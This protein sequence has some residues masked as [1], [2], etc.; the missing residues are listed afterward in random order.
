MAAMASTPRKLLGQYY[1]PEPVVSSLMA[2]LLRGP[3]DRFLDPACGDG[4]FLQLHRR[5]TGIEYSAEACRASRERA[6]LATV[7]AGDFFV[8]AGATDERFDAV[9]GNPPFIRYQHF[10]G[11][12]RE[13][14]LSLA[15]RIGA[16]FSGL[17]SSWAPFVA[18]AAS[19]LKP[20][21]RLGFVVPAELGHATY[22][23]PLL[24]ALCGHFGRLLVVAVR[25]KL[26]PELSEDAW[27]LYGEGF[28][29]ST[30]EIEL[31][32]RDDFAPM[33]SVPKP[34]R[35]V[36]LSDWR[37]HGRRLRKHLLPESALRL[38]ADLGALP[39]VRRVSD[40]AGVGVGYVTGANDFFHLTR[41][42]VL[43]W[44]IP[45]ELTRVAVRKGDQLPAD[46]VDTDTVTGWLGQ[47]LP[48]LLL[49]LPPAASIPQAVRAY[50]DSP[51]G[52]KAR[53]AYK[54]RVREPWYSVPG[55]TVPDGFL[56]CMCGIEGLLVR[57][58]AGCVCTNSVHA[59][60][61]R[62]GASFRQLQR[63][64]RTPLSRLSQEVEGHPL[65][66]GLLKLEPREA[67]RVLVPMREF[68]LSAPD[69][70]AV[71]AAT[72]YAR[73]WRHVG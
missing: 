1:T 60:H 23:R 69:A 59:V 46:T 50:L 25:R 5:S 42:Q 58:A 72:E 10:A 6:P 39:D 32:V 51:P 14:A 61:M 20:G 48:V 62:N 27:L 15:R 37:K 55:V 22:S 63:A 11:K 36:R 40:M 21:G 9:G 13:L 29:G 41:L 66:G 70:H 7:M 16:R 33:L 31:V 44:G 8:W 47:N 26:F 68:V 38:Y 53:E 18:V 52:R 34:T 3:E 12:T 30:E 24:E 17:T 45:E 71:E 65:G 67:G 35:V 49:H 73:R 64:W 57:N 19:L 54:C 56:S 28:G 43:L 4:R 2:W